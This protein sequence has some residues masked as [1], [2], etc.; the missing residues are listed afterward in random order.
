M[1][2]RD[3]IATVE[4]REKAMKGHVYGQIN[5][6]HDPKTDEQFYSV[7]AWEER[8]KDNDLDGS[9]TI[10]EYEIG[11]LT[12]ARTP[13]DVRA[14]KTLKGALAVFEELPFVT[15]VRIHRPVGVSW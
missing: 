15:D 12:A 11:Q 13:G 3:F 7:E 9:R 14:F 5:I 10:T 4:R 2:K 1:Q 8:G 6:H